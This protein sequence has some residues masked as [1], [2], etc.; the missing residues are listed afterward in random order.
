MCVQ[1]RG[2]MRECCVH[3]YNEERERAVYSVCVMRGF[4]ATE[5][6]ELGGA[7]KCDGLV[8][9]FHHKNND[10]G[11][12]SGYVIPELFVQNTPLV[13]DKAYISKDIRYSWT[14]N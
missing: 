3:V 4:A 6:S 12:W 7:A 13:H 14:C 2:E 5:I 1:M 10:D 8:L 9:I 11:H